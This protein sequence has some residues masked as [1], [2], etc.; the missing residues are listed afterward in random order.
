M[1]G[2]AGS[3]SVA[4]NR[5]RSSHS[6]CRASVGAGRLCLVGTVRRAFWAIQPTVQSTTALAVVPLVPLIFGATTIMIWRRLELD[7]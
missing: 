5:V 6:G 1:G 7:K 4:G 3:R 2:V